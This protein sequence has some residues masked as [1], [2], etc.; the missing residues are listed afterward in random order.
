[1]DLKK[2]IASYIHYNSLVHHP[3]NSHVLAQVK[4]SPFL[5]SLTT[6][7]LLSIPIVSPFPEGHMNGIIQYVAFSIWL[8]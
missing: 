8:L 7:N 4:H 6:T 5:N 3:N 2:C 1:M